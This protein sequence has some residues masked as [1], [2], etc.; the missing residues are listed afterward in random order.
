M[1]YWSRIQDL[2]VSVVFTCFLAMEGWDEEAKSLCTIS[3]AEAML[4]GF[5]ATSKDTRAF[6]ETALAVRDVMG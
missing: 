3:R 2:G 6:I 4:S 5:N 1:H